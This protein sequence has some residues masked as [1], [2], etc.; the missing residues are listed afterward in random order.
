[1]ILLGMYQSLLRKGGKRGRWKRC[2]RREEMKDNLKQFFEEWRE[3]TR[4][5]VLQMLKTPPVGMDSIK[6]LRSGILMVIR[7]LKREACVRA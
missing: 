2:T 5:M 1:M 6:A 7:D 4:D 3:E